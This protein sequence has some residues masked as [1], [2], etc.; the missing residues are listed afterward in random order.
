MLLLSH[1]YLINAILI[2][3][4]AKVTIFILFYFGSLWIPQSQG[5]HINKSMGTYILQSQAEKNILDATLT[6]I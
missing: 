4:E 5:D 2:Q 1:F 3:L 6:K